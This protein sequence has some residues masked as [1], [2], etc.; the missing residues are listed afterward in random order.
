MLM[1]GMQCYEARRHAM[2]CKEVLKGYNVMSGDK[3]VV[4]P[5]LRERGAPDKTNV[6]AVQVVRAASPEEDSRQ[7]YRTCRP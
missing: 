7:D 5:N 3:L 4:N 6:L 2:R 1:L